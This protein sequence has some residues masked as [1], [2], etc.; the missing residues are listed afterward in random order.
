MF[1]RLRIKAENGA[2]VHGPELQEGL[3]EEPWV[4]LH[5]DKP[6]DVCDGFAHVEAL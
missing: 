4:G 1:H 2:E 6:N 3:E 5:F